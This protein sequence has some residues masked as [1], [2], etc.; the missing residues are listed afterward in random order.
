MKKRLEKISCILG[1][2][3]FV[4]SIIFIFIFAMSVDVLCES[5]LLAIGVLKL[6][7]VSICVIFLKLGK[8]S[9]SYPYG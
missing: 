4:F 9:F 6:A 2:I 3:F 7:C 5:E 1:N 8:F